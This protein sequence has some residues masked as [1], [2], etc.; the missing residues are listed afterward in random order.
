MEK[1]T[2]YMHKR[3]RIVTKDDE[4]FEGEAISYEVG[5]MEDRD[6]D[7]I[8]LDQSSHVAMI[9]EPD[10]KSIEVIE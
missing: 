2:S 4:V 3:L 7:S 9:D 5:E 10:I 1:L 8:G 6:Y